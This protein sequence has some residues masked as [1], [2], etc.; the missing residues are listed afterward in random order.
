V[1]DPGWSTSNVPARSR[2]LRAHCIADGTRPQAGMEL[3]LTRSVDPK[4]RAGAELM[5]RAMNRY[6]ITGRWNQ[7]KGQFKEF[8][9]ELTDDDLERIDGRRDQFVGRFQVDY[10][11]ARDRIRSA[12]ELRQLRYDGLS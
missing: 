10:G 3:M 4:A 2:F 12:S 6:R 1:I 11:F 9:G 7:L 8:W 5:E